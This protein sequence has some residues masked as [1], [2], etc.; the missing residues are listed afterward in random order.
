[1][2][3]VWVVIESGPK[4]P[5][6]IFGVFTSRKV[7]NAAFDLRHDRLAAMSVEAAE[8]TYGC[9]P[10]QIRMTVERWEVQEELHA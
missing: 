5:A 10:E 3:E 1:M 8:R 6:F 7:A 2:R 9:R 4:R